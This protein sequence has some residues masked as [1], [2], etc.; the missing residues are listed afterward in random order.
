M[1]GADIGQCPCLGLTSVSASDGVQSAEPPSSL[2]SPPSCPALF[3]SSLFFRSS[4]LSLSPSAFLPPLPPFPLL[5]LFRTFFPLIPFPSLHPLLVSH[6]INNSE[7]PPSLPPSV[8]LPLSQRSS[9]PSSAPRSRLELARLEGARKESA[10]S[11]QVSTAAR[12][13][14]TGR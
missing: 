14:P 13:A 12:S 7:R 1:S 9:P 3:S 10:G 11:S 5:L 8:F 6:T 4:P 2:L